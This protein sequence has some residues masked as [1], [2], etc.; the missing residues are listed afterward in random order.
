MFLHKVALEIFVGTSQT[1]TSLASWDRI[2]RRYCLWHHVS[3]GARHTARVLPRVSQSTATQAIVTIMSV[4]HSSQPSRQSFQSFVSSSYRRAST[5]PD[6]DYVPECGIG[7]CKPEALRFCANVTS[8][9]GYFS[10]CSLLTMTLTSYVT[11]QVS[12]TS[13]HVTKSP[14]IYRPLCVTYT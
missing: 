14:A 2:W 9:T 7:S 4:P 10:I 8:F 5:N 1:V 3:S 11:S 13:A 6:S 12:H